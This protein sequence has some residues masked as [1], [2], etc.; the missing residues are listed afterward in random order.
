MNFFIDNGEKPGDSYIC[1]GLL[2]S[3]VV[4]VKGGFC[5]SFL[6]YFF[7]LISI[8]KFFFSNFFS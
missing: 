6:N 1:R 4:F 3:G 8:I 7:F 5:G 2:L